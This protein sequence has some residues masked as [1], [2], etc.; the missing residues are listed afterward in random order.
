MGFFNN[1]KYTL[2]EIAQ[3]YGVTRER[4]R[5]IELKALRKLQKDS[6][7]ASF[8]PKYDAM[9]DLDVYYDKQYIRSLSR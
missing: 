6:V 8:D 5:Q 2:E 4:I 7:F 1:R 3:M 9:H